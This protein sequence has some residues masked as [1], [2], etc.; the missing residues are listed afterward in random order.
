[1]IMSKVGLPS[2][3]TKTSSISSTD[4]VID[5]DLAQC[6]IAVLEDTLDQLS[7]LDEITPVSLRTED[8][9]VSLAY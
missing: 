7:I 2:L 5:L 4:P 1:M 9:Q 6:C 3:P 8:K